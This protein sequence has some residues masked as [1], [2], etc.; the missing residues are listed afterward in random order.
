MNIPSSIWTLLIGIGLTLISLWYGQNHGLLPTS[1]PEEAELVDGLFNT[2][3]TISVG[4][5]LLVQGILIYTAFK[6]RRRQGDNSDGAPVFGNVPLE[7]LWTAI[8]AIVVLG[9]SIYSF[10]VYNS[11]GGFS[12]HDMHEPPIRQEAAKIPGAT[13]P[14]PGASRFCGI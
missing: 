7:I 4:L 10:E 2:M 5:F 12:P 11:I 8:P 1:A 6:Y 3:M 9:I 13:M 14:V